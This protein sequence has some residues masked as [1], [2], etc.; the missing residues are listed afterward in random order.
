MT[1]VYL[2]IDMI[3]GG[4]N[5]YFISTHP[6]K[7]TDSRNNVYQYI[8]LLQSE[9]SI[10][11]TYSVGNANPAQR[12]FSISFDSRLLLP[13]DIINSGQSIAGIAEISLQK[14]GGEYHNRFVVMR[15]DMSGGVTTGTNEEL[16][17]TDIVD[18]SY[19]SDRIVPEFFCDT[20]TIPTIPDSYIGHR[21]PLVFDNYPYVPCIN[22]SSATLGPTFLVC[23]G[24]DHVVNNIYLNGNEMDSQDN[25]RGWAAL[26]SYDNKGNAITIVKFIAAQPEWISGDTVYAN[27]SRKPDADGISRERNLIQIIK[28]LL[29]NSSLLTEAGLDA[30]L[31]GRAEQKLNLLKVRCLINGSGSNDSAKCLDYIQ[32]TLCQSFPMLSFTFTGRGYGPIVTDRR[33]E[34]ITMNLT[35]RKG[36]LYDRKSDLQE[37]SKSE[38][39]NS[40]TLKYGYDSLNNNYKKIV[41]RNAHNSGLC[42][43]SQEQF[44]LYDESIIESIV[45]YEDSVANYV[46]DWMVAHYSLPSYYIEYSGSP[47]LL[48]YLKLGDNIKL[49]DSD[50]SFN[51]QIGTITKLEYKKGETIIGIKLW[52]LYT[53]IGSAGLGGTIG[54]GDFNIPDENEDEEERETWEGF[55]EMGDAS[56]IDVI[57]RYN[58]PK[59][60]EELNSSDNNSSSGSNVYEVNEGGTEYGFSNVD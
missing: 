44:G 10:N 36:L 19:T 34:F 55:P 49:T 13:I 15:G 24:H 3:F 16:L 50:F 52:I 37:S 11:A 21:Y 27:I 58:A 32:N 33:N 38:I 22:T 14:D 9:P 45:I 43:I 6:I 41:T 8:P 2:T 25:Y 29:I 12:S 31:F 18:P 28:A 35:A 20:D 1:N 60:E 39:K 46:L 57:N 17:T 59:E 42:K 4:N 7:T 56:G 54:V 23:A 47:S 5:R 26:Y 48:F 51:E 40:F 30:D 53:S